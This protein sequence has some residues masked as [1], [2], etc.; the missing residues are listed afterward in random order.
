M[1]EGTGIRWEMVLKNEGKLWGESWKAIQ[2]GW[3]FVCN[4]TGFEVSNE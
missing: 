3:E 1:Q 2:N 4:S